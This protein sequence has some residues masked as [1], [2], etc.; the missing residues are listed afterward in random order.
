DGGDAVD[1]G[2]PT[3][4]EERDIDVEIDAGARH[5]LPFARVA[6]Q[7]D[8]ARQHHEAAR[9]DFKCA[10]ALIGT[11]GCDL[12]ACGSQRRFD[13]LAAEQKP[14]AVDKNLGHDVVLRRLG[15]ACAEP[16]DA[17]YFLRKSSTASF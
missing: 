11:Y 10:S 9:I 4:V 2:L 3:A 6:L 7:I 1:D 17:S 15:W 12:P 16:A 8:D 5:H 13:E 14:A